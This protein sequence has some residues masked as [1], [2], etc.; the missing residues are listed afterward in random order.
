MMMTVK[1]KRIK[2]IIFVSLSAFVAV[3]SYSSYFHAK[4][5]NRIEN[6]SSSLFEYLNNNRWSLSV[7]DLETESDI[8]TVKQQKKYGHNATIIN[9]VY[10]DGNFKIE[11]IGELVDDAFIETFFSDKKLYI[12]S[13]YVKSLSPYPEVVTN[14]IECPPEFKPKLT[15]YENEDMKLL[16]YDFLT[17]DRFTYGICSDDL[18]TYRGQSVSIYCKKSKELYYI[19]FSVP[20]SDPKSNLNLKYDSISCDRK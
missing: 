1:N 10:R 16:A 8:V 18:A 14:S 19:E 20:I 17:N 15:E 5:N 13:N 4:K 2:F 3:Y 6:K 7:G 12:E 11:R 9:A